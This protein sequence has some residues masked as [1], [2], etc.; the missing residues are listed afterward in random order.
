MKNQEFLPITE[1]PPVRRQLSYYI[2]NLQG[3]GSRALQED[4][5]AVANAFDVAMIRENGLFF[6]VC[7]GM[8][9]MKDGLL[10][11]R[12][13]VACLRK[14][15]QEMDRS[16]DLAKQLRKSIFQASRQVEAQIGGDGG[17]TAVAGILYRGGLFYASVGDSYLFLL[18]EGRLLRMN[19]EH[20]VCH[21]KYLEAIRDGDMNPLPFR[22]LPDAAALTSFLGMVGLAEVDCSIRPFPLEAGDV[23]LACSDGIGAA[24]S[25]KEISEALQKN[26]VE[27]MCADLKARIVSLHSSNQD[28]YTAIVVKCVF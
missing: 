11:S 24:L 6:A 17:S 3:I 14:A 21:Q 20:N 8:G 25:P 13:A 26:S 28:N 4:S 16:R 12:T 15:F 23:L 27:D 1:R 9:G 19:A 5:F 10:A 22:E 7:D 2:A 18:R